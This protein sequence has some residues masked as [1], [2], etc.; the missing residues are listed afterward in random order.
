MSLLLLAHRSGAVAGEARRVSIRRALSRNVNPPARPFFQPTCLATELCVSAAM[1]W[2]AFVS[3]DPRPCGHVSRMVGGDGF[4]HPVRCACAE[5]ALRWSATAVVTR[6]PCEIMRVRRVCSS[7]LYVRSAAK[8]KSDDRDETD[9]GYGDQGPGN[10]DAA[11]GPV[12]VV[13]QGAI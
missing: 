2:S 6:P 4:F 12:A 1:Q 8:N 7:A 9:H 10:W 11:L 5:G 3:P 13:T